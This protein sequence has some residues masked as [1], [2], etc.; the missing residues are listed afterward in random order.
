MVEVGV[1]DKNDIHI[2]VDTMVI[3]NTSR[4]IEKVDVKQE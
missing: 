2:D 1:S 4:R 3:T